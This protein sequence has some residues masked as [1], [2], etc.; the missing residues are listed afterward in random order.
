MNLKMTGILLGK[1]LVSGPKNH[2]FIMAVVIPVVLS[3][4][5]TLVFGNLFSE[6]P[7]LGI[8]DQGNSALTHSA[9]ETGVISVRLFSTDSELRRAVETGVVHMGII[10]PPGFD[11]AVIGGQASSLEAFIWGESLARDRVVL[12]TTLGSL[13]RGISGHDLDFEIETIILGD[14]TAVPWEDR[15]LPL[16][17][18]MGVFWGGMLLPATSIINEK[19]KR[20]MSALLVTPASA[21]DI[22]VSKALMGVIIS[23]TMGIV[24]LLINQLFG[25]QTWL[26][27]A[28][29][30]L[31]AIMSSQFGLL[32]GLY[33]RDITT[34]FATMK[35]MGVLL[36]APAIIYMFPQLPEWAGRFFPTFYIVQ[37]IVAISQRGAAWSDISTEVFILAGLI[38]IFGVVLS[39]MLGR[40]HGKLQA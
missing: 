18:L 11:Q 6:K 21:G 32:L 22:F 36:Y 19:Q 25:D 12:G 31:G 17:I 24:V 23:L 20:T 14:D 34:L 2:I 38:V 7:E 13:I 5:V 30:G 8:F 40:R 15:L 10:L 27:I 3:L 35:T 29:L 28:V 9:G 37:P 39:I 1:E 16:L 33:A 4:V 26:L